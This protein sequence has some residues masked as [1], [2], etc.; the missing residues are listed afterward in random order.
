MGALLLDKG[1][2]SS[3][4]DDEVRMVA[5]ARTSSVISRLD[6]TRN[7]VVTRFLQE[8]DLVGKES[9]VKLLKGANLNEADLRGADLTGADLTDASFIEADL[10]AAQLQDAN[11]KGA[12]FSDADLYLAQLDGADLGSEPFNVSSSFF[13]GADLCS[14]NLEGATGVSEVILERQTTY[15]TEL[16]TNI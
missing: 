11:L 8:A 2:R 3:G 1:L 12:S 15:L 13:F 6:S 16:S 14:A 7:Q 4:E 9:S 10:T 5:R